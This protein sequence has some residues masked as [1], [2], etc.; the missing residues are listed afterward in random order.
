M[1]NEEPAFWIRG[2]PLKEWLD[3]PPA[4]E[5]QEFFTYRVPLGVANG[6]R[7]W[8][9]ARLEADEKYLYSDG[10]GGCFIQSVLLR[11][12]AWAIALIE[13]GEFI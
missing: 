5:N 12:C 10:S 8:N 11:R 9:I 3:M 6:E 2:L 4:P 13:R 7:P 1:V